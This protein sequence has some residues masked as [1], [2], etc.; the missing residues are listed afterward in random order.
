MASEV[1]RGRFIAIFKHYENILTLGLNSFSDDGGLKMKNCSASASSSS[2][3]EGCCIL[4]S[5]I[6]YALSSVLKAALLCVLIPHKLNSLSPLPPAAE[7]L[8]R[9]ED[10]TTYYAAAPKR[11]LDDDYIKLYF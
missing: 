3:L 9:T 1:T 11:R 5:T 2:V 6:F 10:P 4:N 8:R 7:K